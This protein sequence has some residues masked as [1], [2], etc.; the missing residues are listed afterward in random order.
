MD[1]LRLIDTQEGKYYPRCERHTKLFQNKHLFGIQLI[2]QCNHN[3]L[4][5]D[6]VNKRLRFLWKLK[7]GQLIRI[8]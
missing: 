3:C 2:P 7:H 1:E 6:A 8:I 5:I 4:L